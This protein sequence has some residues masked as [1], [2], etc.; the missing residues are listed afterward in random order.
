MTRLEKRARICSSRWFRGSFSNTDLVSLME[1]ANFLLYLGRY[2]TKKLFASSIVWILSSAISFKRRS[3]KVFHKRSIFPFVSGILVVVSLIPNVWQAYPYCVKESF[4]SEGFFFK[5][6]SN[7][8]R[9]SVKS[10]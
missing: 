6:Y 7:T 3:W 4:S 5:L 9:L 1:K 10:S 2:V 8:V